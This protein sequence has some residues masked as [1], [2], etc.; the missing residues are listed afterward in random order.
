MES[1]LDEYS[2]SEEKFVRRRTQ[3]YEAHKVKV[4]Q[5]VEARRKIRQAKVLT[6]VGVF[7][8]LD[9]AAIEEILA[10]MSF[11]TYEAGHVLCKQGEKAERFY[12]IV[13]GK[14]GV[15][16]S[17]LSKSG[18]SGAS[19]E[20]QSVRV[21]ELRALDIMGENALLPNAAKQRLR[22][23]TVT[24][25]SPVV[26]TLELDRKAFEELA[27]AGIIDKEIVDRIGVVQEQRSRA[28]S[29]ACASAVLPSERD[30]AGE[31]PRQQS[32]RSHEIVLM[33]QIR[34]LHMKL[35]ECPES[36]KAELENK[37]QQKRERLENIRAHGG[38]L[39]GNLPEKKD[40]AVS[41]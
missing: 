14:C 34:G 31:L 1:I 22:S 13:A 8:H 17:T 27:D 11:R 33:K 37:I 30:H 39:S 29:K 28:N 16:Q 21:G 12:V 41:L 32:Q 3:E 26:K 20:M 19:L 9:S 4:R 24:A 5:R 15:A 36:E 25:E 40:T 35:L 10:A 23:A 18:N 2:R 6:K 7:S 38:S